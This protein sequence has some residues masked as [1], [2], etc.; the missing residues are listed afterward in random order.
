MQEI[1]EFVPAKLFEGKDWYIAFYAFNPEKEKLTIKRI[2]INRIKSVAEKR[3]YAKELINKINSKLY[4][5]WNPFIDPEASKSYNKLSDA[6]NLFW[7]IA[8][9]KLNEGII[10]E[11]TYRDNVSYLK[12]LQK[13]LDEK[14][15]GD[16]YI[17]KLTRELAIEFL[18]YIYIEKGRAAVTRN[19]YLA[20]LSI[21]A[22]FLIEKKYLKARFTDGITK[23]KPGTKKRKKLNDV[24]V[25]RLRSYL[26]KERPYYLLACELIYYTFI[27]PKEM[28]LIKLNNINFF[29]GTIFIPK[30]NSKNKKDA[31]VTI[32]KK[33][34]QLMID[35]KIHE[36]PSS[37][38][39]FSSDFKPGE[40][41]KSEKQFRDYWA[42]VREKLKFPDSYQFYSLKDTGITKMLKKV[43]DP[44]IVRDQ[45]RHHSISITNLYA[46]G[47]L[48][49]AEPHIYNL[50]Y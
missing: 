30:E 46:E 32:P 6:I 3:K 28:S 34:G 10:S 29:K 4:K 48:K 40:E 38:Y 49:K 9:K 33:V 21:F 47:E 45:A 20:A 18:D 31:I 35:L 1:Q 23:I 50:D 37:S 26:Q 24:D 25:E 15:H 17:Y 7:R 36:Y 19:N 44:I 39:L 2:K 8:E 42:K 14:G 22:T 5:G 43:G 12:N 16:I 13:W 27:R 11:E 41:R